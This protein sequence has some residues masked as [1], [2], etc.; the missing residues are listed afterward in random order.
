[1]SDVLPTIEQITDQL[2][3]GKSVDE[4]LDTMIAVAVMATKLQVAEW[5]HSEEVQKAIADVL[6]RWDGSIAVDRISERLASM[7]ADTPPSPVQ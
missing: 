6:D 5:L 4:Q 3:D 7:V 1:M 2:L